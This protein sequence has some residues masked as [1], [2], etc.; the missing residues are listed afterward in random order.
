MSKIVLLW[1]YSYRDIER[2]V[3]LRTGKLMRVDPTDY[4]QALIYYFGTF[5]SHCMFQLKKLVKEGDVVVDIGANIGFYSIVLSDLV[6]EAGKVISFEPESRNYRKLLENLEL[7]NISNVYAHRL[8]LGEREETK[9]IH[10]PPG[11]NLGSYT[12]SD[13]KLGIDLSVRQEIEVTTLDRVAQKLGLDRLDFVKMDIEGYEAKAI[14]GMTHCLKK[15]RP[16]LQLEINSVALRK[17]GTEPTH[18][19]SRLRD[20]NYRGYIVSGRKM[21]EI[22]NGR[23]IIFEECLFFPQS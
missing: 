12:I 3:R 13:N 16:I 23:E 22:G 20:L 6:G 7:N 18:L 21:I 1:S 10:R 4:L 14:E 19:V 8:G 17:F 2:I 5:E 15:F 11:G 9:R